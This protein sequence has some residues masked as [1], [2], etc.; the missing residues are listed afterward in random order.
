MPKGEERTNICNEIAKFYIKI[1]HLF[2]A[3]VTTINPEYEYTDYWGN[4]VH[5]SFFQ[6]NQIPK[7]VKV[8]VTK[9]NLCSKHIEQLKGDDN[10]EILDTNAEDINVKPKL[11]DFGLSDSDL[12]SDSD[13][14]EKT[15]TLEKL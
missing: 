12:D 8:K 6:K 2:A 13:S 4:K 15:T 7:G 1:A 3:I 14:E 10:E 11:C 9:L 5:K